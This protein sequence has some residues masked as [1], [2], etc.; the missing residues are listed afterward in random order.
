MVTPPL[1]SAWAPSP[2]LTSAVPVPSAPPRY[3]LWPIII[4]STNTTVLARMVDVNQ[5]VKSCWVQYRSQS[6]TFA[7]PRPIAE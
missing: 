7:P 6:E 1:S 2:S 5:S 4:V 3:M